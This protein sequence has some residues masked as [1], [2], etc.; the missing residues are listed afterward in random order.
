MT[1]IA[2]PGAANANSYLDVATADAYFANR[3]NAAAWAAVGV[4][5]AKEPYLISATRI[6]ETRIVWSGLRS[7]TTQALDWPRTM[8]QDPN[9]P[10]TNR[11]IGVRWLDS[12]IVPQDVQDACC[13]MAFA[14]IA[15]DRTLDASSRGIKKAKVGSLEVEFDGSMAPPVLCRAARDLMRP[16]GRFAGSDG[17]IELVRA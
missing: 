1:L 10:D 12:T 13:E 5:A 14:L 7:T 6:L 11:D 8:V 9:Y 4:S 3:P 16:Y 15:S 2:T 17:S